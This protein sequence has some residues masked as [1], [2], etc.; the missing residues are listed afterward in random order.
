M[1]QFVWVVSMHAISKRD[2]TSMLNLV[3]DKSYK[4]MQ[5]AFNTNTLTFGFDKK[6]GD[7]GAP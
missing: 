4:Q 5:E 2:S 3:R 7:E 6:L 1:W